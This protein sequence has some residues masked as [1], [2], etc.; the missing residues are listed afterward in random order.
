MTDDAPVLLERLGPRLKMTLNRPQ[1]INALNLEIFQE[2]NAAL[3]EAEHD[4]DIRVV[5]LTGSGE[6]GFCSGLDQTNRGKVSIAPYLYALGARLDAF[7][8]PVITLIF[9]HVVAGAVQLALSGDFI[10]AGESL[11][12]RE[13]GGGHS[14]PPSGLLGIIQEGR[15]LSVAELEMARANVDGYPIRLAQ[16]IG[17]VRAKRWF[18]AGEVLSAQQA[19][20]SGMVTMVVPD[21]DLHATGDR[22]AETLARYRPTSVR[23]T[24]DIIDQATS[25]PR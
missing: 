13:H 23:Y 3:D 14:G 1:V 2:L 8:K 11:K 20:E 19:F 18:L 7:P 9:G 24:L 17:R 15:N 10:I 21:S 16:M 12:I 4:D 25:Q 5:V 22:L 6:R